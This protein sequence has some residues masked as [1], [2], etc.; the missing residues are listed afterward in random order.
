M[1]LKNTPTDAG[2]V[3]ANLG[4][5]RVVAVEPCRRI[6][7]PGVADKGRV[8]ARVDSVA[9]VRY[10][11]EA[12]VSEPTFERLIVRVIGEM[13]C[14]GTEK[15]WRHVDVVEIPGDTSIGL[16]RATLVETE[17]V[18]ADAEQG[19]HPRVA[20]PGH[21]L[22]GGFADVANVIIENVAS[23]M[24]SEGSVQ[25]HVDIANARSDHV[26]GAEIV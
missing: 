24:F 4:D 12:F 2:V 17:S 5:Y 19:W 23:N 3:H 20:E 6:V 16:G 11:S 15:V 7:G 25:G 10:D 18:E 14:L 1:V 9:H 21:G 22:P 26:D 8:M 13:A